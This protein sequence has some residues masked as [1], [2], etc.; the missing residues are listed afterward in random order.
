MNNTSWEGMTYKGSNNVKLEEA[1]VSEQYNIWKRPRNIIETTLRL[2]EPEMAYHKQNYR[3]SYL[4]Y[5]GGS[6]EIYR[7]F[8]RKINLKYDTMTCTMKELSDE[9]V[10]T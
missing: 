4:N 8:N 3:F 5:E 9:P 1:R 2:I 6:Y 7:T 10:N